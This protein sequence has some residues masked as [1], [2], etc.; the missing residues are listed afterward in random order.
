M[1]SELTATRILLKARPTR[2][3]LADRLQ[4]PVPEGLEL[5]L[6]R[7]DLPASAWLADALGMVTMAERAGD[8]AWI[9]EAPLRTLGGAFFDLTCDDTDHRDTLRQVVQAGVALGASAA[10][11]HVVAP[12]RDART[13]SLAE[14]E[15]RLDAAL[16]LLRFYE[17]LC[18]DEGLVPQIENIPPVG[19]MRENTYVFSPIGA[20]PS[21]LRWL[22]AAEPSIRLTVDVS[23][24][25]LFLN[26][27]RVGVT[28]VAP[29]LQPV[30]SFSQIVDGPASLDGYLS[31]LADL[32]LT[33][34]VSN[35]TGL[36]GE[37]LGYADGDEDLDATLRHLMGRVG[38]LV[39]ETLEANPDRA[40]GMRDAQARLL[41]L[42]R[43]CHAE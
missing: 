8:F 16:P 20:A 34:H 31:S 25:A 40:L 4:A 42:R 22:A 37:G 21:D 15:R 38:F 43:A 6:D 12:T 13:L 10:N 41:A 36:L 3:Q 11:V 29:S 1:A 7:Q 2:A 30:A 9:V 17:R 19:R 35:A 27:R 23:H 18:L 33:V 24:A 14:R 39:T 28:E 26:W 5:Y 32:T